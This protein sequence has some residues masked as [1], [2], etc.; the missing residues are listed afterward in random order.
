MTH[1]D[2]Y[3]FTHD[4][5]T[6]GVNAS[7]GNPAIYS[8]IQAVV[9]GII[10]DFSKVYKEM[11]FTNEFGWSLV[12]HVDDS[13][14]ASLDEIIGWIYLGQITPED[15][16]ENWR[17]YDQVHNPTSTE[18]FQAAV[19][20]AGK[21]RNFFKT[22]KVRD[23][24]PMSYWVPP[25]IQFYLL[26]KCN[27]RVG[28]VRTILFYAWVFSVILKRNYKKIYPS[29]WQKLNPFNK[30]FKLDRQTGA[31]SQKNILYVIL[32]DLKSK[33]LIKL[34]NHKAN[35]K[36]YFKEDHPLHQYAVKG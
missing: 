24:H 25:Q 8:A 30:N 20:C 6:D 15:F 33:W 23:L 19:Y 26:K 4:K 7:S 31:V 3:G 35:L 32:K 11:Y 5:P 27:R 18:V 9:S 36:A 13:D 22:A 2:R 1:L 14:I 17:W 21:H 16:K 10:P 34:V 29:L 12:R 28:I